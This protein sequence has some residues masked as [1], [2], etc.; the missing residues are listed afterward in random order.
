MIKVKIIDKW[1]KK[2][3][4]KFCYI[5]DINTLRKY[6]E[7]E[8]KF[9]IEHHCE[10]GANLNIYINQ[11]KHHIQTWN[12]MAS[13]DQLEQAK[14]LINYY[15]E[16]EYQTIDELINNHLN[17]MDTYFKIKLLEGDS[18]ILN[19]YKANHPEL[20]LENYDEKM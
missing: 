16:K 17:N 13:D 12:Y 19:E 7:H 8:N 20:K 18:V 6:L 10:A 2:R 3:E 11:E 15:D 5:V 14:G 9:I 4:E 1:K